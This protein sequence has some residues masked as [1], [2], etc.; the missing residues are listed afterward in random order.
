MIS[1]IKSKKTGKR[2]CTNNGK[3]R[4]KAGKNGIRRSQA[5]ETIRDNELPSL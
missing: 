1:N 2:T 3:N 4:M 5:G